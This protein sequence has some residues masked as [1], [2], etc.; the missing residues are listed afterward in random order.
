MY[1]IVLAEI[2]E[3]A[4]WYIEVKMPPARLHITHGGGFS[5]LFWMLNVKHKGY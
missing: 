4:L 3:K 2:Q 5:L 1:I